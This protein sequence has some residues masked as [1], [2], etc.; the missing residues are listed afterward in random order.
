MHA[1]ARRTDALQY[2]PRRPVASYGK[3]QVI[4]SRTCD[5]LYLVTAGRVKVTAA[6]PDMHGA[7]IRIIPQEG[8]FG[9]SC[10]AAGTSVGSAFA[11]E[12]VQL[13]AWT[14]AELEDQM[15][16]EPQLGLALVEELVRACLETHDRLQA[17]A[18]CKIPERVMRSLLQLARAVGEERAAGVLRIRALP[19]S[20]LGEYVGTSREV[21][22]TEMARLQR[23]GVLQYTR[24]YIDVDM[25]VL[26]ET[27]RSKESRR[28][29]Q[30]LSGTPA[31]FAAA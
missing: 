20:V 25:E 21:V 28:P 3:G 9:E 16:K 17:M 27:L 5:S 26:E 29:T 2:L 22:S 8:F 4:Y 30:P 13:M 14:R 15:V 19:Q 6:E 18:F 7:V 1:S 31:T 12:Q 11:L 23:L 24:G 10:L